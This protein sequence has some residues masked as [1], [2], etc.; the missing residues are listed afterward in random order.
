MNVGTFWHRAFIA[1]LNRLPPEEATLEA[2]LALELASEHWDSLRKRRGAYAWSWLP[3]DQVD[4][5][6]L[7]LTDSPP[8]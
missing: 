2:D 7:H 5:A 1:A 4:V 8:A 3:A 6:E